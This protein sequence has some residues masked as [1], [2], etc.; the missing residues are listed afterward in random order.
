[1]LKAITSIGLSAALAVTP[2]AVLVQTGRP[3]AASTY[4]FDYIPKQSDSYRSRIG[5]ME[6][7]SKQ[8]SRASAD[9]MRRHH[10]SLF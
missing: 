6:N 8:R 10:K 1:M 4:K 3:A 9:W 5:H 2:L 7:E